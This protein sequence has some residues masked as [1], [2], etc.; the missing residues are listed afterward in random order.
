MSWSVV[1]WQALRA[2]HGEVAFL[3]EAV[4]LLLDGAQGQG[5]GKGR[6]QAK[7]QGDLAAEVA[8]IDGC[9][10]DVE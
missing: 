10:V 5:P 9:V 6:L 4:D 8:G 3:G 7:L 1:R 2:Q